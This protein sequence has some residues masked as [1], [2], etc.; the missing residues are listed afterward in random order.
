MSFLY[1]LRGFA[2]L[3]CGFCTPLDHRSLYRGPLIASIIVYS[4]VCL[5]VCAAMYVIPSADFTPWMMHAGNPSCTYFWSGGYQYNQSHLCPSFQTQPSEL[6]A[7]HAII[8]AC[9]HICVAECQ[10]NQSCPT[11]FQTH[12]SQLR[13]IFSS[14]V[15]CPQFHTKLRSPTKPNQT[16]RVRELTTG[17]VS[18]QRV[19]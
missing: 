19:P 10:Y 16:N 12:R 7:F 4:P 9:M 1:G 18:S 5:S 14:P 15:T 6:H 11:S 13:T 3:C 8:D 2:L 17:R